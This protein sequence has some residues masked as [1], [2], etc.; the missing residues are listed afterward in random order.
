MVIN[1]MWLND[2]CVT[3]S[4]VTDFVVLNAWQDMLPFLSFPFTFL[5]SLGRVKVGNCLVYEKKS[6][7]ERIQKVQFTT[8]LM[9]AAVVS[10]KFKKQNNKVTT[11]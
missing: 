1:D 9:S 11:Q 4:H 10:H 8:R 2:N 6:N 7:K 5:R 3:E